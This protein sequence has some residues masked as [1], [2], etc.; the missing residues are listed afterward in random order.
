VTWAGSTTKERRSTAWTAPKRF[1]RSV[2][3]TRAGAADSGLSV[4]GRLTPVIQARVAIDFP[5]GVN[6]IPP[7]R[8][9]LR[10]V[11]RLPDRSLTA[12]E[13]IPIARRDYPMVQRHAG[14]H[15]AA[16]PDEGAPSKGQ[17]VCIRSVTSSVCPH[18]QRYRRQAPAFRLAHSCRY[19]SSRHPGGSGRSVRFRT[20]HAR[21][22]VGGTTAGTWALYPAQ[23]YT[24]STVVTLGSTYTAA[25]RPPVNADGSSNFNAT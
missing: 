18:T 20:G 12:T 16:S 15:T 1:D 9:L 5:G 22:R 17:H 2:T 24:D 10:W 8:Y 14:R 21:D 3:T 11:W 7:D 19:Q 25:A 4:V 23:T 6:R 13:S